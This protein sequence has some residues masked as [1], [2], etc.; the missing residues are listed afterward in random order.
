MNTT[1]IALMPDHSLTMDSRDIAESTNKQHA[2]VC[3]DIQQMLSGIGEDQSRYGSVYLAGNGENR[4][5][6][7]LPYRETMILISGYSIELRAKVIDRWMELERAQNKIPQT[8]AEALRLAADQQ[9][10]IE[11]QQKL[12]A[13]A[14][15]KVEFY[16]AVT[17]SKDAVDIGLVAK[18][19]NYPG[20][21]RNKLF[22]FLRDKSILMENNQPY[23]KYV[24]AG[25]FKVI[26]TKYP[27]PDGSIHVNFK[28]VVFQK[29]VEFIRKLLIKGGS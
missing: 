15:P 11:Q 17:G 10:K 22:E 21:G 5:C 20:Y 1:Q 6:Y 29:G 14:A 8:Y 23:Q 19:I 18:L 9:E 2:H 13:E 25:Y 27:K 12:L 4:R 3:R 7:N 24:D 16:D 26:E 28:T